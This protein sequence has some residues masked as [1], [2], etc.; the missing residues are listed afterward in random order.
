MEAI[1]E[2]LRSR[3]ISNRQFSDTPAEYARKRV[4][5]ANKVPGNLKG[6]N[7]KQCLNR[8]YIMRAEEDGTTTAIKCK[9]VD[10]RTSLK[11]LERSGL[12]KLVRRSTFDMYQTPKEWQ[13]TAKTL[14]QRYAKDPDGKW[15]LAAGNAGSGKT[16]LCVAICREMMLRGMETRY[17][18]WREIV[19][20]LRAL[21]FR[22]A[23][24]QSI[25]DEMKGV[26]VLYIDDFLKAG[27]DQKTGEP[28]ITPE[29]INIAFEILNARYNDQSIVT[30]ISSERSLEDMIEIDQALGSRIYERSKG[31]ILKLDGKEKNWRMDGEKK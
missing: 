2:M 10:I 24:Y 30:V 20:R 14:A 26:R 27:I 6:Y 16:H 5:W 19:A 22:D 1:Q 9:C 8:G 23:E 28:K 11:I 29:D 18:L 31:F 21:T 3:G 13:R 15:F 25:M 4:E 12:E 17:V 7:C